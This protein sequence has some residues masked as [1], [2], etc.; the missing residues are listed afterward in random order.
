MQ[1]AGAE[2]QLHYRLKR[3]EYCLGHFEADH[4]LHRMKMMVAYC[5]GYFEAGS[6]GLRE[7]NSDAGSCKTK[8]KFSLSIHMD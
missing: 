8:S 6:V 5:F 2:H 3:V 1:N 7:T 4:Q